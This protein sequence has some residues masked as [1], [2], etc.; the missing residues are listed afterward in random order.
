MNKIKAIA[1][2]LVFFAL[3]AC[4]GEETLK[5]VKIGEQ[6][7]M[8]ENLNRDLPGSKCH[9]NDPDNCKKY[10]RLYN[11]ETAIKAC[12]S[13]WHLPSNAE[14][15]KLLHYV[16]GT[17][18]T[19]S[20]YKSKTAGKYLK[21]KSGWNEDGNGTDKYGFAAL[22]GDAGFSD[23]KFGD[24]GGYGFWWSATENNADNAYSLGMNSIGECSDGEGACW[25]SF[26]KSN[27]FSVR[28]LQD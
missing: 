28:C 1:V 4:E 22:P 27:L 11:W 10:G 14:W 25:D 2:S 19:K 17:K 24:V 20:P 8:A 18:G 3:V 6:T 5:T 15:D 13:G 23:D 7:W 12:P 26:E 9:S 21:A 16:D